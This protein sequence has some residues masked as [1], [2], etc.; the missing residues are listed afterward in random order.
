MTSER[1]TQ[2]LRG[3]RK[4]ETTRTCSLAFLRASTYTCIHARGPLARACVRCVRACAHVR[5]PAAGSRGAIAERKGKREKREIYLPEFRWPP[6]VA[7]AA[8]E[9]CIS[10]SGSFAEYVLRR[11]P[12][13]GFPSS[14]RSLLFRR[15]AEGL[16][17]K[18]DGEAQRKYSES[19]S[20]LI[21]ANFTRAFCV[22][23]LEMLSS[24]F[25]SRAL[26]IDYYQRTGHY[27]KLDRDIR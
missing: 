13:R 27:P 19:F 24:T 18:N 22:L 12:S 7:A 5:A 21:F 10:H 2:R 25:L 11:I 15:Q 4:G 6:A 1:V 9:E 3:R 16:C 26:I 23:D 17:L 8:S 20:L 14:V